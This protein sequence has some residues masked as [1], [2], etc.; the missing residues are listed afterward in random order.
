[1]SGYSQA[2]SKARVL[3]IGAHPDDTMLGA[4][5]YLLQLVDAGHEVLILT[6]SSGELCGDP[7]DREAEDREAARRMGAD[8]VFG[9]LPDGEIERRAAIKAIDRVVNGFSPSLVLTHDSADTNQDHVT[10]RHATSVVCRQVPCLFAYEGPSS[11]NFVPSA[12]FNV[13]STWQRKVDVLAAYRSQ[14]PSKPLMSWV[15]A[16]GRFRGWPRHLGAYCEAMNIFHADLTKLPAVG[17]QAG[18]FGDMATVD[19]QTYREAV[20]VLE[21]V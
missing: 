7:G 17:G 18:S 15:E 3:A 11:V 20:G 13:S 14:I 10:V 2:S 16:A 12:T 8:I 19:G 1:M 6:M 9:R 5:G 4:G 21:N